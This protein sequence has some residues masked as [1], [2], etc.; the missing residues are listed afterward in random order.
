[1][2]T[3]PK[4]LLKT[5]KNKK[6]GHNKWTPEKFVERAEEKHPG[7]YDYVASHYL[8]YH[9]IV[10]IWCKKHRD[11]FIQTVQSHV[12]GKK[13][14]GCPK[15]GK[16]NFKVNKT[17]KVEDVLK[18]AN[19]KHNYKY[20]YDLVKFKNMTTKIEIICPVPGHKH[21][22][23]LQCNTL[24]GM[25]AQLVQ[26][27]TEGILKGLKDNVMKGTKVGSFIIKTFRP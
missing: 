5:K 27:V 10:Q 13:G 14:N 15:C 12:A 9:D 20:N 6:Y 7:E 11:Y 16:E 1:M 2:I 17:S 24:V 4:L 18:K 19:I 26:V 23:K 25:V 3:K 22:G 8:G 21:F